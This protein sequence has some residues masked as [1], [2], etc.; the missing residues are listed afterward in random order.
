M[1]F[2]YVP[3]IFPTHGPVR[4]PQSQPEAESTPL[5]LLQTLSQPELIDLINLSSKGAPLINR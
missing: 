4:H 2:L 1:A 5:L 3:A